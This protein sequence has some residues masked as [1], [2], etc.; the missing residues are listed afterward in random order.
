LLSILV[1]F[2]FDYNSLLAMP[3][4][5]VVYTQNRKKKMT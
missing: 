2:N 1:L 3:L 5:S 4:I